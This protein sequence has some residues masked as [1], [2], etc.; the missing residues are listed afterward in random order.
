MKRYKVTFY[1]EPISI[2]VD[3]PDKERAERIAAELYD[4]GECD[5]D[6]TDIELISDEDLEDYNYDNF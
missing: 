1:F 4:F 3:A 2:E 5:V 6:N